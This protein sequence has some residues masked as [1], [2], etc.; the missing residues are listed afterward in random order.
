MCKYDARLLL[1]I[2]FQGQKKIDFLPSHIRQYS[3]VNGWNLDMILQR[4]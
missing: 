4:Q 3:S 1:K 2:Q